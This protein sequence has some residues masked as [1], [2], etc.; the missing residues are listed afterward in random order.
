MDPMTGRFTSFDP[1]GLYDGPNGYVYV[2]NNPVNYYDPFGLDTYVINRTL[3]GNTSTS[4]NNPLSHTYTA[5][6]D[7]SGK[8]D[9]TYSWGNTYY[10]GKT[11]WT[12][13]HPD[14]MKAAQESIDNGQAQRIGSDLLDPYV[15]SAFDELMKDPN[16]PWALW[17]N[18]KHKTA[19]LLGSAIDKMACDYP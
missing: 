8:V 14:D 13:N 10:D 17:D 1:L 15:Q 5:T 7:S 19:D 9:N 2:H 11:G 6:T 18:C 16:E 4:K 12:Q 3:G